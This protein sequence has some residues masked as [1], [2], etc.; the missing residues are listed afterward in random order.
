[1]V[2][3]LLWMANG[4]AVPCVAKRTTPW[5]AAVY[6]DDLDEE[7][8]PRLLG[9]APAEAGVWLFLG[10]VRG[11][12][13]DFGTEAGA[14]EA[15]AALGRLH[16]RFAR[17]HPAPPTGHARWCV[18]AAQVRGALRAAGAAPALVAEAAAWLAGGP[19]TLVHGDFHRW[20]LLKSG[21]RLLL[22]DWEHAAVTHP[23]WDL[24]LAAPEEETGRDHLPCGRPAEAALRAYHGAGPLAHL[25]WRRFQR[26]HALARL[27]VAARW[28]A[29]HEA[30]A[31][32]APS[33]AAA[34]VVL[35]YAGAER[36][37]QDRLIKI[38]TE[39][40]REPPG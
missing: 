37:R 29:H 33:P 36:R 28:A 25:S 16:R 1:M 38:L 21:H 6:R 13:P 15:Y 20:N 4:R 18:T 31:L 32:R 34:D 40:G 27:F 19:A 14:A 23:I 2:H 35:A 9:T 22:L 26:L 8:A 24:V 39:E 11:E 10:L 7:V 30:A 17:P 3:Q 5:E 12:H